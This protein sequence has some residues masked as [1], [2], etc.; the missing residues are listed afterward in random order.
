MSALMP[1]DLLSSWV[2]AEVDL[3]F[4]DMCDCSVPSLQSRVLV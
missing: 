4:C 2:D 1:V 3:L